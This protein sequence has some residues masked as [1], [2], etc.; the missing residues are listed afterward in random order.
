MIKIVADSGCEINDA[1]RSKVEI[2]I[3]KAPLTLQLEDKVYIDDDNL[4]V[5]QYIDSMDKCE[6]LA[7]TA[8]PSPE[9]YLNSFKE[10]GSIFAV[11]LSSKLSGSYASAMT[12][13]QMY[14]DEIGKKII[15]VFD[16]MSASVGE[17]LIVLKI[18]E[19]AK[20]GVKD[21]E[22]I[23][24][25]TKFIDNMNTYFILEKF[26]NLVKTGRMDPF[27]AKIASMLSINPICTA[28][29]GAIKLYDKARGYK[30]AVKKLVDIM[31]KEGSDFENKVL[32]I[33]HCKAIEKATL[34]KEEVLKRVNFKEILIFETSGLCSTYARSGGIIIAF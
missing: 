15:H 20:K 29:K 23:E 1:L 28:E 16:S 13:K 9:Y 22:I 12:A 30:K 32:G 18:N 7:K 14:L 33:A 2:N 34:L 3:E 27:V 11:T 25:V 4:D 21:I 8:A 17:T 31:L 10:E 6:T 26:D 5:S 19:L 24:N